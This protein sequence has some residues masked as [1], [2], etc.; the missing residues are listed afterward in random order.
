MANSA[1]TDGRWKLLPVFP[2][3]SVC[4]SLLK[5]LFVFGNCR[6]VILGPLLSTR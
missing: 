2:S 4:S 1:S 6:V 3:P 5:E